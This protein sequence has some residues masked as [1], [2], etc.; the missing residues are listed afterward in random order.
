MMVNN[1]SN[2]ALFPGGGVARSGLPLDFHQLYHF[3]A[4]L[5]RVSFP[6]KSSHREAIGF[7]IHL[8]GGAV[9]SETRISILLGN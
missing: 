6:V 9:G 7:E 4:K 8:F 1:P 5:P 2:K 3:F